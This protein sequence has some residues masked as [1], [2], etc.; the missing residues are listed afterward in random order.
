MA[1]EGN[2]KVN[3]TGLSD[4]HIPGLQAKEVGKKSHTV[5]ASDI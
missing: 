4:L 1:N 5:G 2:L 3:S